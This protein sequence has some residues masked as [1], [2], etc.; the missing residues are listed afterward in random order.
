MYFG[1][2]N[3][4]WS[5]TTG[6]ST[7]QIFTQILSMRLHI[8]ANVQ[9]YMLH[10]LFAEFILHVNIFFPCCSCALSSVNRPKFLL[11][12][13]WCCFLTVLGSVDQNKSMDLTFLLIVCFC[14]NPL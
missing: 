12:L 5:M 6:S 13:L 3:F 2:L 1:F 7:L 14:F 4:N 10:I 9:C 8:C 11:E